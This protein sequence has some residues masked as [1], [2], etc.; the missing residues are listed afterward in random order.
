MKR[1]ITLAALAVLGFTLFTGTVHAAVSAQSAQAAFDRLKTLAGEWEAESASGGKAR[2]T[3]QLSA[4]GSTVVEK[5]ASERHGEMITMYHLDG[6]RLLLTHYCAVNNQPRMQASR[7]DAA[8]GELDFDFLDAT[9]LKSPAAGHMRTAKF[10][11]AGRDQFH[12][13]WTFFEN[14]K[15]KMTE[16]ARYR[17]VR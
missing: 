12:S 16:A 13:E 11:F 17:R 7:F 4:G 14:G 10:R 6:D 5:Y 1:Y 2:V 8:N 9:N 3:Y 15:P